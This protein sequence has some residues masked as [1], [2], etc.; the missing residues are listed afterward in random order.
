MYFH[1]T[2]AVIES[3]TIVLPLRSVPTPAAVLNES[4]S[5]FPWKVLSHLLTVNYGNAKLRIVRG[6]DQK[7]LG[8]LL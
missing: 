8:F 3:L 5:R 1:L 6:G 4:S 2:E 7:H